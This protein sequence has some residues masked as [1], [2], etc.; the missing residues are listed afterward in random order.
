MAESDAAVWVET[1]DVVT[2][3]VALV[4]PA[5]T[6]TLAGTRAAAVLLLA[7]LIVAPPDGAAAV[8]VT[9]AVDPAPPVTAAGFTVIADSA[10]AAGAACGV[11][12][13]AVKNDPNTPSELRAR[14]RHH[15]RWA[16][17]PDSV[18]RDWVA[19]KFATNGAAKVDESS[20]WTS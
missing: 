8:N 10:A 6:A 20:T 11:K 9:V 17:R 7:R 15:R 12:R 14:T 5:A 4:A 1:A 19:E 18:A 16:G 3:T 2:V 13:R